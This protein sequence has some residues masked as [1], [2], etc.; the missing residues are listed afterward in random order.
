M[1]ERAKSGAKPRNPEA[2]RRRILAAARR[3]FAQ[4]GL[5]GARVDVIARRAR[6]N[7]QMLYHHFGGKEELYVAVLEAA[8]GGMREAEAALDLEHL[9]PVAALRRLIEFTWDYYLR[10]PDFL[11]LVNHENLTGARYFRKSARLVE[12]HG[13]FRR[14]LAEI[15]KRGARQGLFRRG[16][17]ADQLNLTIAAIGYYYLTNRHT[18]SIIFGIDLVE[19]AALERR[20]AFNL[21]TV[22]RLVLKGMDGPNQVKRRRS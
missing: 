18:N 20:L 12:M 4:K 19:P 1:E 13:L 6:A 16:I 21:E 10:N 22:L 17:D 9:E 5:A 2:T 14:R 8:Y 15:L 7:K 11:A 3:E